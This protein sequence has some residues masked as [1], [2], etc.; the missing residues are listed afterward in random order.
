MPL[1]R[2]RVVL[3]MTCL[4]WVASGAAMAAEVEA[5]NAPDPWRFEITPYLWIASIDGSAEGDGVDVPIESDYKFFTVDNLDGVISA[6]FTAA[7]G[8]WTIALD[9][10]YLK[11]SDER[12]GRF[13][14]TEAELTG[15]FL[16]GSG[17]YRLAV[18][19]PLEV[20]VGLRYVNLSTRI[21]L[22][23]G[24]KLTPS[25][26][27][28]DPILGARYTFTLGEKWFLI[29]HGDIGGFG[30]SSDL[31]AQASGVLTWK[32]TK[33]FALKLG[34]RYMYMDFKEGEGVSE[35]SLDG[36]TLGMGFS[37]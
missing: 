26:E 19:E 34:Y 28:L 25:G 12:T 20:L 30:I 4:C 15:G 5:E 33:L 16:E 37:F 17:R 7:K 35:L 14:R 9:G 18:H 21:E 13:I 24:P 22:T 29:L 27:W 6:D 2:F 3:F 31:A 36:V 32:A 8:R 10:L 1:R 23:P 11:Y